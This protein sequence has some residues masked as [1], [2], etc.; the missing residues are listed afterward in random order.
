MTLVLLYKSQLTTFGLILSVAVAIL[1]LFYITG[2]VFKWIY[3]RKSC[4]GRFI[5][6]L[7]CF[8]RRNDHS[9]TETDSID[10]IPYRMECEQDGEQSIVINDSNEYGTFG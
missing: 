4:Y 8:L 10:S 6:K 2:L 5:S 9:P 7:L 3:S 1:P